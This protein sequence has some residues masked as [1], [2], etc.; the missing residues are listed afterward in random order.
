MRAAR[1]ERFDL[2]PP[3]QELEHGDPAAVSPTVTTCACERRAARGAGAR[4][5]PALTLIC[6]WCTPASRYSTGSSTVMMLI[7]ARLSSLSAPW[8]VVDL[9]E[10]VGP[11]T[12]SAPV[13]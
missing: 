5:S 13:G 7:S 11:V 10:P 9:P 12:S 4:V 1:R 6:T 2:L 3:D 8:S